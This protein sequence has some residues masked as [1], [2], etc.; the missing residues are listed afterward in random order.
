MRKK[1]LTLASV[2]AFC[3]TAYTQPCK[4]KQTETD[5]ISDDVTTIVKPGATSDYLREDSVKVLNR[6]VD[7]TFKS[8]KYKN[9]DSVYFFIIL[10]LRYQRSTDFYYATDPEMTVNI[11]FND[12]YEI[13]TAP[14]RQFYDTKVTDIQKNSISFECRL[15]R[16]D[17]QHFAD[18][19]NFS[20][21]FNIKEKKKNK[22]DI[23]IKTFS[24]TNNLALDKI[25]LRAKC[26]LQ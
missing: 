1:I 6:A 10:N 17:I 21:K 19:Y 9:R 23:A 25:S 7:V 5:P 22:T 2:L 8:K 26:L 12:G 16:K 13:R 11:S 14:I 24:F 20:V 15:M 3:F 4:T 18:N